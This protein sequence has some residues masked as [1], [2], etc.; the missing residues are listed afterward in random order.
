MEILTA[1]LSSKK[2]KKEKKKNIYK[3]KK[4]KKCNILVHAIEFLLVFKWIYVYICVIIS[5]YITDYP[6]P[7]DDIFKV[8]FFPARKLKFF[9]L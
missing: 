7:C 8:I 2:K 9:H 3:L 5:F 6:I 4:N 1:D